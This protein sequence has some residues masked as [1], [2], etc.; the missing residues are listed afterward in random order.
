MKTHEPNNIAGTLE[1]LYRVEHPGDPPR[2]RIY[3]GHLRP[4][5]SIL[6]AYSLYAVSYSFRLQ[7]EESGT[8]LEE[9]LERMS[10]IR[11]QKSTFYDSFFH[12]IPFAVVL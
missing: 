5:V 10:R 8:G 12:I 6:L 7:N 1:P 3:P 4:R 9:R 2:E 11:T